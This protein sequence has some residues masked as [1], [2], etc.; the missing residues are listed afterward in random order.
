[1]KHI[2]LFFCISV[3]LFSCSSEDDVQIPIVQESNFYALNVGNSW[4]Y[5]YYKRNIE[6]NNFEDSGVIDSV[7]IISTQ[8]INQQLYYKFRTLTTGNENNTISILQNGEDFEFLRDSLGFLISETGTVNYINND[9]N[10][11]IM[12]EEYWGTVYAKLN[13]GVVN[14]NTAA[15]TFECLDMESYVKNPTT[16]IIYP[17]RSHYYYS[18]GVGLI[19]DTTSFVS[20]SQ[21]IIE[22]RL[23]SYNI[24]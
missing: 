17:G 6:T 11:L 14:V 8:E 16:E 13:E 12:R 10:E 19:F 4:V 24:Q 23:D 15:G 5:K 22:R 21:H 18:S 2:I 20:Q 1:M 9:Y 7:S 3:L